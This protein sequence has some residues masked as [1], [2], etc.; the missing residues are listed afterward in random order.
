MKEYLTTEHNLFNLSL[1]KSLMD[2]FRK[3]AVG[4][5]N[6]RLKE[7]LIKNLKEFGFNF[8]NDDDFLI[9]VSDRLTRINMGANEYEFYI[10]FGS[11]NEKM[12]GYYNDKISYSYQGSKV[13]VSFGAV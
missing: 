6:K 10:D 9:F 1:E 11:E 7:Y 4:D 13:T 2:M 8:Q 5:F 3:K 12:V